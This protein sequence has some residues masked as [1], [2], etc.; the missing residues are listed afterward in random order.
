MYKMSFIRYKK[1]AQLEE[2]VAETPQKLHIRIDVAPIPQGASQDISMEKRQMQTNAVENVRKLGKD[3]FANNK[4]VVSN[5]AGDRLY[6]TKE[7]YSQQLA[8]EDMIPLLTASD[9]TIRVN[10]IREGMHAHT[11]CMELKTGVLADLLNEAIDNNN[12]KTTNLS[13]TNSTDKGEMFVS[14]REIKGKH[15]INKVDYKINS[16]EDDRLHVK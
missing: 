8:V 12:E 7:L 10:A 5:T 1:Q 9:L 16:F 13:L 14:V 4:T 3:L 2:P 11:T 15:Y 6:Q